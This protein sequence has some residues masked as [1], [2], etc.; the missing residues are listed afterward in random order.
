[1][2]RRAPRRRSLP[3][4]LPDESAPPVARVTRVTT[5]DATLAHAENLAG[6]MADAGQQ[7]SCG[8]QALL[9]LAPDAL[10]VVQG[11]G[12]ISLVNRHTE[13]LFGYAR[14]DLVGQPVERLFPDGL[15][16]TYQPHRADD[17]A[18]PSAPV[19][20][21]TLLLLGQRHDGTDLPVEVRLSS[22]PEE[23]GTSLVIVSIREARLVQQREWAANLE[24]RR[25]QA[26]TD[27]ALAHLELDELLPELLPRVRDV[28]GAD[29]VAILLLD[30]DGQQ[31]TVRA[32]S[33]LA[34]DGPVAAP[35][36]VGVGLAGRIA[37]SR[38]PLI[39]DDVSRFP[40][41]RPQLREAIQSAM[42][43]PLLAD[44]RLLGV[45]C[46]GA[47]QPQ[48]FAEQDLALLE[49][50]AERIT[51]A[52][53]RA[54]LFE[55]EQTAR[56]EAERQHVRWHAAMESAP[57]FVI[58]CDAN[59]RMT[60]VNPAYQRL[61]GGPA[62]P[63]VSVEERPG[64]YGLFLPDGATLFPAEQLPLTRALREGRPVHGVQMVL[65]TPQGEERLVEWEAAPMCTALG[66]LLGA[67]AIG[68]DITERRQME[69]EREQAL[70][71]ELAAQARLLAL[72]E[73]HQHMIEF[74]GIASH[75]IRTPLATLK[76]GL[77]LMA[78]VLQHGDADARLPKLTALAQ[79]AQ[80]AT[81]R[82]EHLVGQFVHAAGLQ[83]GAVTMRPAAVALDQLV[84]ECVEEQRLLHP[85]RAM[86]VSAISDDS[87]VVWADP[88]SLWQVVTNYLTNALKF[89]DDDRPVE[90]VLAHEGRWAVVSVQDAG[91]GIPPEEQERIWDKFYRAPAI[92][93]R[94]G[95]S[96]G[97][98]LGLHICKSLIE[99]QGGAVGARSTHGEGSIFW[100][101]LPLA[102]AS[103]THPS[104]PRW[105][106]DPQEPSDV[107]AL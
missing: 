61:R 28:M 86:T 31:L 71:R 9:E 33:R 64:R 80:R 85:N 72:E 94:S 56:H 8:Y 62:D 46:V 34:Q 36:P 51:T 89:S 66:E 30:A 75:E 104:P 99:Q 11:N 73:A 88:A 17:A 16:T 98:G 97:F 103:E 43:V 105:S 55:A 2:T 26:L 6:H 45:L 39:V 32:E 40:L 14:E 44:E 13:M 96:D 101:K 38:Q 60:Y 20:G 12:R 1:M 19:M 79:H 54:Q 48:H 106:A 69:R 67:V 41:A 63:T 7:V 52:I 37:A 3:I 24:L 87:W 49:Q 102:Q 47:A 50:A 74:L 53:E 65:R 76:T 15:R 27:T 83:A 4:E 18:F 25:L 5:G 22:L 58:T 29:L 70:A 10:V 95:S 42:G 90:V 68:H 77:Q 107:R 23:D 21:T 35:M 100:F 57:E 78:R 91:P 59:L 92:R 84:R 81:E 93:H 82:L